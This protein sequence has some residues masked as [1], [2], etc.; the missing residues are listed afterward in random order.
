MY[1]GVPARIHPHIG[2]SRFSPQ[3]LDDPR[4]SDCRTDDHRGVAS[5]FDL[6][7]PVCLE[8]GAFLRS[9]AVAVGIDDAALRR[10]LKAGLLVRVRHGAYTFAE[11]WAAADASER[12][13]TL[14]RT[15]A[16]TSEGRVAVSHHSAAL[17]HG[18]DL[19]DVRLARAHLTRLDGNAGR[20]LADAV[21]HEGVCADAELTTRSGLTVVPAARAALE[22]ALLLDVEHG[23]CVVDSGLRAELFTQEDLAAQARR[24]K[25][26]PEGKHLQIVTR[27][28]DGRKESIGE[29]R[30]HYMFWRAGL[31]APALQ[32]EVYDRGV[33]VG[34]TD[35]AWPEHGLLGEF[36]GKVKYGK[37]LRPGEDPGDAVFREKQREDLLRRLTGWSF[38]RITWSMLYD[39]VA[40]IRMI[41]SMM[42]TAA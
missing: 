39:P 10:G 15:I 34:I 7:L 9:E 28:A 42:R 8:H 12:H 40:T 3:A 26:W 5:L 11:L 23:L 35:F 33:L 14:V 27:L 20:V 13:L 1:A 4:L 17:L 36:D 18:M 32:Y 6:M 16:R 31:P 38:V 21:H 24:M 37:Y 29:S 30:S 41:R 22:S 25:S 2:N 19:W